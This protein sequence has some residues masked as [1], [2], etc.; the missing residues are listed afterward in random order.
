MLD[1]V[2]GRRSV[3]ARLQG[4]VF[5]PWLDAY[6]AHLRERVNTDACL[7]RYVYAVEHLGWWLQ[8][9][10]LAP[11]DIGP[12]VVVTF[13][14]THLPRCRCSGRSAQRL[15]YVR[16]ALLHLLRLPPFAGLA[17]TTPTAPPSPAE[18]LLAEYD[19]FLRQVA[20]LAEATRLYRRRYV[21]DFLQGVAGR[22][23]GSLSNL[24][25]QQV[26]RFF[27]GYVGHLRPGSV[28][29]V[30]SSLRSFLRFLR[31]TGR[32]DRDLA[33]AI[34][35]VPQ[36]SLASLPRSLTET[37][38][39]LFLR[40]FDRTTRTGL[41][42]YAM[43]LCLVDLGLRASE[44]AALR[45]D[46]VD[47]RTGTVRVLG[48]KSQRDRE[49]PL[50]QAIGRAITAYLR[51]ARPATASRQ[52]FVRHRR[53]KGQAVSV[54]LVRCVM[55]R[56]LAQVPGCEQLRG[57]HVLRHTAATRLFQR[58]VPLKTLADLLGHRSIDTTAI[59]TKVAVPVL[60]G[61]ALP[62]PEVQP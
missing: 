5:A 24:Q 50:S 3:L 38:V 55:R 53:R 20:G 22:P 41:R 27:L 58:G 11:R 33:A 37:Q 13:L 28:Q 9:R 23:S 14:Q 2:F 29:V 47:W 61:V 21:R 6:V 39:R 8:A 17:A 59:Y 40:R 42:D 34:P 43:A 51:R 15:D 52:L 18:A 10:R 4:S 26:A 30:A 35:A 45:L 36:W 44:V 25:P 16:P 32:C 46:D 60:A 49:L 62:W 57:T 1:Q 48:G 7:R 12:K 31:T 56:A 19:R 54:M